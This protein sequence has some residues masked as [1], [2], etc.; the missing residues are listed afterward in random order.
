MALP[1]VTPPAP[2][3]GVTSLPPVI[4]WAVALLVI[5]GTAEWLAKSV[6]PTAGYGLVGIV[7]VAYASFPTHITQIDSFFSTVFDNGKGATKT[8]QK[9]TVV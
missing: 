8:P 3:S 4:K 1:L 7:V 5:G 9:G 6:S 2:P